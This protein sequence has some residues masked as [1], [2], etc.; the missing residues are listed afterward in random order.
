M[1]KK[2]KNKKDDLIQSGKCAIAP[3]EE[4]VVCQSCI[5]LYGVPNTSDCR[6]HAKVWG[7]PFSRKRYDRLL[8]KYKSGV[9]PGQ[10]LEV[11]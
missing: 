5:V 4:S 7:V 2:R 6:A 10:V 3:H 11:K 9:L 1:G 8:G